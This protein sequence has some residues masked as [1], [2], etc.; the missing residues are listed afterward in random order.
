MQPDR[1]LK[2][3]LTVIAV[4]LVWVCLRDVTLVKL[5][6]ADATMSEAYIEKILHNVRKIEYDVRKLSRGGCEN[7]KLC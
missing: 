3:V 5:A 2:A 6:H 4:C 7:D 1:Y